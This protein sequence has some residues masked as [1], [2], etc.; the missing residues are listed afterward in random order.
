MIVI[1]LIIDKSRLCYKITKNIDKTYRI[2]SYTRIKHRSRPPQKKKSVYFTYPDFS[3]VKIQKSAQITRANTVFILFY[4][5]FIV[6]LFPLCILFIYSC[7]TLYSFL[8]SIYL[9]YVFISRIDH[10]SR[11]VLPT[12]A[13]HC[14]LST[15]LVNEKAKA[16][17]RAMKI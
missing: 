7:T 9:F 10:S 16:R 17:Y 2:L 8:N 13:R 12:V 6:S 3:A 14:V 4:P 11:G 1:H 15:N 5:F